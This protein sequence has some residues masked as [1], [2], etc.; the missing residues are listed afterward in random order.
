MTKYKIT[1]SL[2]NSWLYYVAN[3]T[4]T[5]FATFVDALRG[6]YTPNIFTDAG[7]AFEKTVF[8][9]NYPILKDFIVG[10]KQQV[11]ARQQIVVDNVHYVI[12]GK[13]DL[14]DKDKNRIID[15]KRIIKKDYK[16][17]DNNTQHML[18]FYL[19]PDIK[20]F[21]YLCAYGQLAGIEGHY[22]IRKHR[23]S[24][25]ELVTYIENTIRD[26]IEFLRDKKLLETYLAFQKAKD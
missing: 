23:P 11:S 2:L 4:N 15:L 24:E 3:P 20:E 5:N 26:F 9:G 25:E 8:E 14:Y 6:V 16:K 18:Y 13:I 19:M 21:I 1:A 17:Y 7:H 12:S 10:M 22:Y